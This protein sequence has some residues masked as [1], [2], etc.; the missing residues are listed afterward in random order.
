MP[1]ISETVTIRVFAPTVPPPPPPPPPENEDYTEVDPA[2]PVVVEFG[3]FTASIG[4]VTGYGYYADGMP[5]VCVA[6]GGTLTFSAKTPPV[7]TEGRIRHGFHINPVIDPAR[8]LPARPGTQTFDTLVNNWKPAFNAGYDLTL[9]KSLEAGDVVL[10][11]AAS[12]TSNIV[13]SNEWR[14]GFLDEQAWLHVRDDIPAAGSFSPPVFWPAEGKAQRPVRVPDVA[15]VLTWL[16]SLA[17]A[18]MTRPVTWAQVAAILDRPAATRVAALHALAG[19]GY[20]AWT[21]R[22]FSQVGSNYDLYQ[23]GVLELALMGLIGD[24]WSA[25]D[26][27][28][29]LRRLLQHGCQWFDA[30]MRHGLQWRTDGGHQMTLQAPALLWAVATGQQGRLRSWTDYHGQ[31]NLPGQ[32]YRLTE[33]LRDSLYVFR[34]TG[35]WQGRRRTV[36]SVS[37]NNVT[38]PFLTNIDWTNGT[39]KGMVLHRESGGSAN[40]VGNTQNGTTSWT[41]NLDAQPSPAITAG[42]VIHARPATML[43]VGVA[44]WNEKGPLRNVSNASF[45]DRQN[46]YQNS[47]PCAAQV[48]FLSALQILPPQWQF[49]AMA[50]FAEQTADFDYPSAGAAYPPPFFRHA[51]FPALVGNGQGDGWLQHWT[52]QMWDSHYASVKDDRSERMTGFVFGPAALCQWLTFEAGTVFQERTGRLAT[53]AAGIGDP[54]GT[55]VNL[56]SR[57]GYWTATADGRRPTLVEVGGRR[58]LRFDR[59]DDFLQWHGEPTMLGQGYHIFLHVEQRDVAGSGVIVWSA[60]SPNTDIQTAAG[61]SDASNLFSWRHGRDGFGGATALYAGT[62]NM[63]RSKIELRH[64]PASVL[65]DRAAQDMMLRVDGTIEGTGTPTSSALGGDINGPA[66]SHMYLGC[67]WLNGA[68]SHA[69]MDLFGFGL[70]TQG[71]ISDAE[72]ETIRT[73]MG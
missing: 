44:E 39:W 54:V 16:P 34:D 41:F 63:A 14:D 58:A 28:A 49:E 3:S 23:Y 26:K 67:G 24:N 4:D 8:Y 36:T 55:V 9:P 62:G 51:V 56:G 10:F 11:A 30:I 60:G 12:E 61:F 73:A 57:G 64:R 19:S 7:E 18:G 15:T 35:P 17:T 5:Y 72:A 6:P 59:V 53:T 48:L 20:E 38:V 69:G 27:E 66:L 33:T 1:T 70:Y 29:C 50:D 47:N 40:I 21:P 25:G 68:V 71:D 45:D 2:A 43:A 32:F 65:L 52:K 13:G 37:G 22:G 42:D 46:T 31:G